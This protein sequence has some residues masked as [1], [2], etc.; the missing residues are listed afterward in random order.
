MC[1]S[2]QDIN[3]TPQM[4]SNAVLTG[5]GKVWILSLFV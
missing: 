3:R 5:T 4:S 1:N 2:F